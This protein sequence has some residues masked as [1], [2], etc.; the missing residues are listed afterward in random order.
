MK[1]RNVYF[2]G[3]F[4]KSALKILAFVLVITSLLVLCNCSNNGI[5]ENSSLNGQ[6][7][8]SATSKTQTSASAESTRPEKVLEIYSFEYK[9]ISESTDYTQ[10]TFYDKQNGNTLPYCLYKPKDYTSSKK[11]PVIL[12]LHGAGEIGNDNSKQLNNLNNMFEY[13]GDIV[14]NAFIICPQTSEWWNLDR[15]QHNDYKGTLGSAVHLLENIMQKYSCDSNRVYVMGLSMGGYATWSLLERCGDIFAAGVPICGG[16]NYY[17]GAAYKDIPIKIYHGTADTTVSFSQSELMYDAIVN[18]G[19][20]KVDFIRLQGVGHNAWSYA[21]A[22]REL[23]YW[24]FAQNKAA[25]SSGEYDYIDIF[26]IKDSNGK[27]II[28]DNDVVKTSYHRESAKSD[29]MIIELTLTAR[30]VSMLNKAYTSSNGS[31]FTFYYENQKVYS[32]TATTPLNDKVF[33][34]ADVF[35]IDNYYRFYTLIKKTSNTSNKK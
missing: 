35:N 34:I 27:T 22:D 1:K 7:V 4:C 23:F 33:C 16:G 20:Q 18:A 30:G 10:H 32:F 28:T 26:S 3:K 19:G 8:D 21:L 2:S 12:F 6:S 9:D 24:M 17:N 29:K 25:D 5:Q 14:S 11:Y 15:E 13:N 31:P